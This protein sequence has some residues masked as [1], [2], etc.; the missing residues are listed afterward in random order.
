MKNKNILRYVLLAVAGLLLFRAFLPADYKVPQPQ[1]NPAI[2]HWKLTTGSDIAYIVIPGRG[3]PQE[4]PIIYLYGGHGEYIHK[5]NIESLDRLADEGFDVYLYDQAGSGYSGRLQNVKEYTANRCKRDLEAIVNIIGHTKVNL[6]C[7]SRG[8]AFASMYVAEHPD[9][10]NKMVFTNP[11]SLLPENTA[12]QTLTTPDSLH[13]SPFKD[14][15][16]ETGFSLRALNVKLWANLTGKKLATDREMDSYL[17]YL[18]PEVRWS[19]VC[20]T[21]KALTEEGGAGWYASLMTPKSYNLVKDIR[22]KLKNF[23][24]QVL[25]IKGQ[26]DNVAWGFTNEYLQLFTNSRLVVIPQ[27]GHEL[28]AEQPGLYIDNIRKFLLE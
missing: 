15:E 9:K 8:A 16:D 20:D 1:P 27:A 7:Q 3:K 10:V 28:I 14:A 17:T 19:M 25:V 5:K 11:E 26:C 24:N 13:L 23:K 21:T 18:R 6:I 4:F 22:S 12:L 2:R